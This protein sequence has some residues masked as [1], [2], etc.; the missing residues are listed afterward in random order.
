MSGRLL[1]LEELEDRLRGL[2]GLREDGGAG[3]LQDLVADHLGGEAGD[4]RVADAAL[5]G[6]QVLDADA[7]AGDRVLKAVL[8]RT[9]V[10]AAGVHGGDGG[11]HLSDQRLGGGVGEHDCRRRS[12]LDPPAHA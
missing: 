2:V 9:E 7:E 8:R 5:A 11:V 10:G 6:R 4:V 12:P 3:L 1:L